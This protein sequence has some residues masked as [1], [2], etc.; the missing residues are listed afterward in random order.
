MKTNTQNTLTELRATIS[1]TIAANPDRKARWKA[2]KSI[3]WRMY[4]PQLNLWAGLDGI[5]IVPCA[6]PDDPRVQV[7]DG[8]DNEEIK[9]PFYKLITGIEW[10][11]E[12][13]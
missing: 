7:F 2:M 12:I 5:D 13:L 9:L 1:A 6:S 3:Q 10:Q 11:V 8:R 4:C